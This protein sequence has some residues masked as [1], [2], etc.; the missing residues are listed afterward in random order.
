MEEVVKAAVISGGGAVDTKREEVMNEGFTTAGV[1]K[2]LHVCSGFRIGEV[3]CMM[4]KWRPSE[5]RFLTRFLI[6]HAHHR[7]TG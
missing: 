6:W 5:V 1:D 3:E 7:L 2:T 4:K